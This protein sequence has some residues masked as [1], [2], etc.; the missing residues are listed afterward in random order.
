MIIC[1]C[2]KC[3]NHLKFK[4]YSKSFHLRRNKCFFGLLKDMSDF[5]YDTN[6]I[7]KNIKF[8]YSLI[9]LTLK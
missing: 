6:V 7:D 5:F 1:F 3:L 9:A 2:K 4:E 8:Y